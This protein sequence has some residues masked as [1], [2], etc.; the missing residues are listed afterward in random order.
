MCDLWSTVCT[1]ICKKSLCYKKKSFQCAQIG[2]TLWLWPICLTYL[3]Y[4]SKALIYAWL[5]VEFVSFG[6]I[7]VSQT[8]LV[9]NY[10]DVFIK[11]GP[12]FLMITMSCWKKYIISNRLLLVCVNLT[13]K[14]QLKKKKLVGLVSETHVAYFWP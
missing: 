7:C 2:L 1:T 8:H 13:I 12:F 10:K 6:G 14:S 3:T 11:T 5:S 9:Q 4:F